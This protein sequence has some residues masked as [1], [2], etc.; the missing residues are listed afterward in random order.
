M[1]SPVERV[2]QSYA[3]PLADFVAVDDSFDP[4][5]LASIGLRLDRASAGA[6]YVAGLGVAPGE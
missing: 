6:L 5:R 2:V 3:I 1:S 4:A